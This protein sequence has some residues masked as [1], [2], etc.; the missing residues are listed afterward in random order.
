[1]ARLNQNAGV[2]EGAVNKRA[3]AA[4]ASSTT[5]EGSSSSS[6]NVTGNSRTGMGRAGVADFEEAVKKPS[7][8]IAAVRSAN[9][10]W[11]VVDRQRLV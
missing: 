5:T 2:I 11:R 4:A 10:D 7:E 3:A 9:R 6:S 1:M 8:A